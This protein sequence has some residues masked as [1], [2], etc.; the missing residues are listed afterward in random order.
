MRA[1]GR[2]RRARRR[3]TTGAGPV[4]GRRSSTFAPAPPTRR[5][6]FRRA[7]R[8]GRSGR[9]GLRRSLATSVRG[10]GWR[11]RGACSPNGVGLYDAASRTPARNAAVGRDRVGGL[12]AHA[13]VADA[14]RPGHDRREV[15][16]D[17]VH[18]VDL[19]HHRSARPR[20]AAARRRRDRRPP[21]G[22]AAPSAISSAAAAGWSDAAL[23]PAGRV[24]DDD[25]LRPRQPLGDLF[26]EGVVARHQADRHAPRA[27]HRGVDP[28]LAGRPAVQPRRRRPAAVRVGD[29]PARVA[30]PGVVADEQG[31]AERPGRRPGALDHRP[32]L[33]ALEDPR[34]AVELGGPEVEHRAVAVVDE[35]LRRAAV[36][37]APDRGVRLADH[38]RDGGGVAAVAAIRR[39]R[40]ADAGDALHV[41]ADVDLHAVRP[42]RRRAVRPGPRRLADPDVAVGE[43]LGLPDGRP[44]LRLVDRVAGRL[45]RRVAMRRDRDDRDAHLAERH[46]AGAVDDREAL[47][48][49]PLGDLVGDPGEDRD[50][51][52]LVGLVGQASTAPTG[53]PRR[54]RLLAR[55]RRARR[56]PRPADEA[57]D[58]AVVVGREPVAQLRED[59]RVEGRLADLEDPA[60]ARSVGASAP[61]LTGGISA[62]SSPSPSAA[63]AS[64][65]SVLSAKRTDDRPGARAADGSRRA[66]P[67][68]P[69]SSRRPAA[70][71]EP[72]AFPRA[73]AAS[74]TAGPAPAPRRRSSP[75]RRHTSSPAP[76][77]SPAA[78]IVPAAI[79]PTLM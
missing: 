51:H 44:G 68:R 21:H 46:L 62:S 56:D 27:Q 34:P 3:R 71:A 5:R 59:R 47:D 52:R 35:D 74:R 28:V 77:Y 14:R 50:R 45:E 66:P 63:S 9:A 39:G 75:T 31:D 16:A 25:P 48:A 4:R 79:V 64:A 2:P 38:E 18:V 12:E 55:R 32:R 65:Y 20:A 61:P 19:D 10:H 26:G 23:L 42:R 67:T 36:E 78:R 6:A 22:R 69:R 57:D 54:L 24:L 58:R 29:R 41:D 53:V 43:A 40:M 7:R 17:A 13:A 73:R 60:R 11:K 70:R 37:R 15:R 1:A 33:L 8:G 49:E 72:P 76:K 30:G